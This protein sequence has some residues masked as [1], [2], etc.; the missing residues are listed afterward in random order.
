M[1]SVLQVLQCMSQLYT[2]LHTIRTY[3]TVLLI[4]MFCIRIRS[5][6]STLD[7]K[8]CRWWRDMI[9]K[10]KENSLHWSFTTIVY[11][12]DCQQQG[13]SSYGKKNVTA[14][15]LWRFVQ[16]LCSP[17]GQSSWRR[18]RTCRDSGPCLWW[19]LSFQF[20]PGQLERHRATC[21]GL[22]TRWCSTCHATRPTISHCQSFHRRF[23]LSTW[24]YRLVV[25]NTW[26]SLNN[27]LT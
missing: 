7:F 23:Y 24:I 11:N 13:C 5:I 10:M 22:E 21:Q 8:N 2:K 27:T 9:V 15:D 25:A 14:F 12:N 19:S 3:I 1:K 20:Q 18:R 26:L 17:S 4:V 16:D 6:N